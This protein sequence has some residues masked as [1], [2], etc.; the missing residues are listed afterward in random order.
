MVNFKV[1]FTRGRKD[2]ESSDLRGVQGK[3]FGA[4]TSSGQGV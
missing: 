3:D 4:L 2:L 1:N